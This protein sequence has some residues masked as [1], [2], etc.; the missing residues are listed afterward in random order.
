MHTAASGLLQY[1]TVITTAAFH[2]PQK[3]TI[4]EHACF[5]YSHTFAA[6]EI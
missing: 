5:K 1:V 3:D 2:T 4:T 6:S